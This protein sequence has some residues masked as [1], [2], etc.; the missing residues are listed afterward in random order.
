MTE[1]IRIF[2]ASLK[3]LVRDKTA[4]VMAV[5]FPLIFV[6][7]FS[8]FDVGFV[9]EGAIAGVDYFDYVLPGLLAIG[10]MNFAMVGAAASVARYRELKILKRIL[11]TPLDPSKFIAGQVSA[12][13][14]L[15]MVQTAIIMIVG[16]MLGGSLG[17]GWPWLFVIATLGNLIFVSLGFAVAGRVSSVDA[18]NNFAGLMTTPLMFFGGSFFPVESLPGWLQPVADYL[19]LTPLIDSMRDIALQGASITDVGPELAIIGA[20]IVGA[21]A[22]ARASFRFGTS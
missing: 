14:A 8:L 19:P 13:L 9:G 12:R 2:T 3:M 22:L 17:E 20:W 11:A 7:T 10:L 21:L 5:I 4:F 16:V 18:A 15:A 6:V 1:T